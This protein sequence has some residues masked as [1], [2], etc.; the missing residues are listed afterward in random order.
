MET[1]D[2]DKLR[3]PKIYKRN[4]RDC[5]LDPIRK[6]LIYVTPEETV[7][8]RVISYL[9]DELKV[10]PEDIGTD[11]GKNT[12]MKI[13]A[14]MFNLCD[15]LLD[16]RKRMPVGD[17]GLFNLIEDYGVRLLSYG[18]ANGGNYGGPYRSFLVDVNGSTEFYS[19]GF[20]KIYCIFISI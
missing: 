18:N 19:L 7:R 6:K 10:P 8:Q 12:P 2:F 16:K 4:G 9:I 14:P 11:I 3:L 13:A 5:Y 17:Y 1:R 15:G 20:K